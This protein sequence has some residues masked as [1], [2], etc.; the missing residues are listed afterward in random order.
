MIFEKKNRQSKEQQKL[1]K[2]TEETRKF[3]SRCTF[4]ASEKKINVSGILN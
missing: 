3:V 4:L 2:T 1:R